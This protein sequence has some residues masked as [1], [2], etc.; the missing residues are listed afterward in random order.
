MLTGI[1]FTL[2]EIAEKKEELAPLVTE[3]DCLLG[4]VRTK[5]QSMFDTHLLSHDFIQEV[6]QA[7]KN[8]LA[9]TKLKPE[10]ATKIVIY[11]IPPRRGEVGNVSWE[12]NIKV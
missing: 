2:Q 10:W 5:L 3:D 11:V 6:Y 1:G 9:D 7:V 4:L 8:G 12:Q